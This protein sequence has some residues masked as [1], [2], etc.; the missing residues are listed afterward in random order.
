MPNIITYFTVTALVNALTTGI[1]GI[2]TLWSSRKNRVAKYV[3]FFCFSL[4]IWA[5][6]YFIW[7][8][9]SNPAHALFWVRGMMV[10]A[11]L[12]PV[13]MIHMT[14]VFL[15]I[16]FKRS[17]KIFLGICYA[18]ALF[19]LLT[20]PFGGIVAKV[21]P[22]LQ[23]RYWPIGGWMFTP[24]IIEFFIIVFIAIGL[25][26]QKYTKSI[27]KEK[28][29]VGIFLLG[30]IIALVGGSTNFLL[31]YN[32]QI[33]PWGNGLVAVYAV[34]T[35]YA[36][37]RYGFLSLA[38]LWTDIFLG[39]MTILVGVDV[40]ITSDHYER[41]FRF[42]L[43]IMVVIFG[44]LVAQSTRREVRRREE[45]ARL[46]VL[47]NSNAK[48]AGLNL[49]LKQSNK[50]LE[51]AN[52]YLQK[53][54]TQKSDFLSIAAHQLR[55]PL[56]VIKGY[57]DLLSDHRFAK[58]KK[59]REKTLNAI[60]INNERL[61]DL[62][63]QFLDIATIEEK[64]IIFHIEPTKLQTLIEQS[65]KSVKA[66]A[67]EKGI[68][69]SYTKKNIPLVSADSKRVSEVIQ[70]IL[71]NAIKY[72]TRK[73]GKIR[74]VLTK[75]NNGVACRITDNGIGFDPEDEAVFFKKFSRGINAKTINVNYGTGLGLFIAK[76]FISGQGGN[77]WAK[78]SGRDKG[79]EFGF[80]LPKV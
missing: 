36:I 15:N 2:V 71:D 28:R 75:K 57:I 65:I 60:N 40:L 8:I 51:R 31:W 41:I 10:G 78:S 47:K 7:L 30:I 62:V 29:Q 45:L 12:I 79:S 64:G 42:I 9:S 34:L 74:V 46:D 63:D 52:L 24:Y 35:V 59:K 27:E 11:I 69:I 26:F 5:S 56:S 17:V 50:K 23:F 67:K 61:I 4:F 70:I 53:L 6:C 58:T 19:F 1:L 38:V 37:M 73:K 21:A 66:K 49:K 55:T 25:L 32:I 14:F 48:L 76:K 80:W 3:A 39:T 54:D 16:D 20:I 18:L 43:F 72:N 44:I 22:R 33:A 13:S 77:I 68:I